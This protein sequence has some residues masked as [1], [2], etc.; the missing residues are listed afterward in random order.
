MTL[1]LLPA[2][3]ET[4]FIPFFCPTLATKTELVIF[5]LKRE[6]GQA[7]ESEFGFHKRR[8]R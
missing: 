2:R 3:G 1:R 8:C 7:H 6:N 4:E 5:C